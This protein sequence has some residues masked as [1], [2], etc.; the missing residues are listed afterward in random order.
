MWSQAIR[1]RI[2]LWNLV[3][4]GSSPI[5]FAHK[6]YFTWICLFL[7]SLDCRRWILL[8]GNQPG[9][10]MTNW[11]VKLLGLWSYINKALNTNE[12]K[13]SLLQFALGLQC[14]VLKMCNQFVCS[15]W[16]LY[17]LDYKKFKHVVQEETS[18]VRLLLLGHFKE[19]DFWSL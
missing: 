10:L 2:S 12:I 19:K 6:V 3:W 8:H 11:C 1:K 7:L 13:T 18:K 16:R 15:N 4:K 9:W 14:C 17:T 5:V